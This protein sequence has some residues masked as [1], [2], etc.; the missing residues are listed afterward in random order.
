M[1]QQMENKNMQNFRAKLKAKAMVASQTQP[2]SNNQ[3]EKM[4]GQGSSSRGVDAATASQRKLDSNNF[5]CKYCSG[6]L[7]YTL[8]KFVHDKSCQNY[9]ATSTQQT[10]SKSGQS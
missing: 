2:K 10:N 9:V 5:T 3:S 1:T 4:S 6:S 7:D 8:K